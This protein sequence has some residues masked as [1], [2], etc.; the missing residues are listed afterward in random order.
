MKTR[1]TNSLSDQASALPTDAAT[2]VNSLSDQASALPTDAATPD[3]SAATPDNRQGSFNR[4]KFLSA[5]GAAGVA[6]VGAM[7]PDMAEAVTYYP[8]VLS[9]YTGVT[10]RHRYQIEIVV[11]TTRRVTVAFSCNDTNSTQKPSYFIPTDSSRTYVFPQNTANTNTH[12]EVQLGYLDTHWKEKNPVVDQTDPTH[13]DYGTFQTILRQKLRMQVVI[14]QSSTSGGRN[15]I[16]GTDLSKTS[17]ANKTVDNGGG[18][19]EWLCAF[20]GT[21]SKS[22]WDVAIRFW[23]LDA[24]F[25]PVSDLTTIIS[26]PLK[27]FFSDTTSHAG[28]FLKYPDPTHPIERKL[29]TAGY[30]AAVHQVSGQKDIILIPSH[31]YTNSYELVPAGYDLMKA[32]ADADYKAYSIHM[33][34]KMRRHLDRFAQQHITEMTK[35]GSQLYGLVTTAAH[36][37]F[38]N[39][40]L[41]TTY[42]ANFTR[43]RKAVSDHAADMNIRNLAQGDYLQKAYDSILKPLAEEQEQALKNN[44]SNMRALYSAEELRAN[45]RPDQFVAATGTVFAQLRLK[46]QKLVWAGDIP[47]NFNFGVMLSFPVLRG[48]AAFSPSPIGQT[49][50]WVKYQGYNVKNFASQGWKWTL[51]G[52]LWPANFALIPGLEEEIEVSFSFTHKDGFTRLDSIS[53]ELVFDYEFKS[54]LY[55]WVL[56]PVFD[57]IISKT[58]KVLARAANLT[59][60]FTMEGTQAVAA[61]GGTLFDAGIGSVAQGL[62]GPETA[63]LLAKAAKEAFSNMVKEYQSDIREGSPFRLSWLNKN[64]GVYPI[65]ADNRKWAKDGLKPDLWSPGYLRFAG[66]KGDWEP[67]WGSSKVSVSIRIYGSADF[68]IGVGRKEFATEVYGI[69]PLIDT[70]GT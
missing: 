61:N 31:R 1:Q 15:I 33:M 48:S 37:E 38:H 20:S 17:F 43:Y 64:S 66:L 46:G 26:A 68:M 39:L 70:T 50:G 2:S 11:K 34:H 28:T 23:K 51:T 36:N 30:E 65:T 54:K 63:D 49:N 56:R 12:R 47:F 45:I 55:D 10:F 16:I 3:A 9:M 53:F 58:I 18:E 6:T 21:A 14:G 27:K 25:V 52:F 7:A 24:M 60:Q 35:S 13:K 62:F 4:R 29:T 57:F 22:N 67:N 41:G 32:S 59:V 40:V 8:E 5:A 42:A 69:P 44:L 19:T